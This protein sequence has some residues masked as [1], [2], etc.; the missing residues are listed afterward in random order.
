MSLDQ[1]LRLLSRT[2]D[3]IVLGSRIRNARLVRGLTQAELG[4]PAASSAYICRIEAGQRRPGVE[5]LQHIATRAETTVEALVLGIDRDRLDELSLA[6]SRAD[7][8]LASGRTTAASAM[9]SRVVDEFG[10]T[11]LTDLTDEADRIRAMAMLDAGRPAA[12][13]RTL[14]RLLDSGALAGRSLQLRTAL[15]RAYLAQ[16]E[17]EQAVKVGELGL[18]LVEQYGLHGLPESIE[19]VLAL[20]DVQLALGDQA[21]ARSLCLQALDAAGNLDDGARLGTAY[22]HASA[23]ETRRGATE[24]AR[25]HAERALGLLELDRFH[26]NVASLRERVNEYTPAL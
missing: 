5:L 16:G 14:Q 10:E 12:A 22:W 26:S 24:L 19:L 4:D 18:D 23:T 20:A 8:L 25:R 15:C 17:L 13:A 3:P 1:H 2:I 21:E 11:P 7:L 9:A 6:L